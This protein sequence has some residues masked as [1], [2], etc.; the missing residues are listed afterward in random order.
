LKSNGFEGVKVMDGGL[1]C[2]PYELEK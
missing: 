1:A 2:W